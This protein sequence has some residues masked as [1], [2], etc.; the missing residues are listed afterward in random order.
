MALFQTVCMLPPTGQ[1][2]AM[3]DNRVTLKR[4]KSLIV[5]CHYDEKYKDHVKYWCRMI[6]ESACLVIVRSDAPQNW[7]NVSI[8]DHPHQHLFNVIINNLQTMDSAIYLCGVETS[9]METYIYIADLNLTVTAAMHTHNPP[10]L[11]PACSFLLTTAQKRAVLCFIFFSFF[12]AFSCG[13]LVADFH[14]TVF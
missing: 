1:G 9:D 5:Q 7:G 10:W 14:L 4:G 12:V 2:N 8:N 13:K 6:S 11:F 3:V